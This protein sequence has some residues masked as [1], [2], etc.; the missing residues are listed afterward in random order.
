MKAVINL[1]DESWA[2]H[3]FSGYIDLYQNSGARGRTPELKYRRSTNDPDHPNPAP[4]EPKL[5]AP[6]EQ[7]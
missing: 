3:E 6:N 4:N 7:S 1:G 2:W 5:E